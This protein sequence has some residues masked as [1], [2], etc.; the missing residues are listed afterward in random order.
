MEPSA[1]SFPTVYEQGKPTWNA[2]TALRTHDEPLTF[3]DFGDTRAQNSSK[4]LV[5]KKAIAL[6]TFAS[7]I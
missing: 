7:F 4:S 1:V 2:G 6:M 5:S 3:Q